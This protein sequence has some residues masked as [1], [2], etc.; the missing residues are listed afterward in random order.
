MIDANAWAG[1][2]MLAVALALLPIGFPVGFT[3]IGVSLLFAGAGILLGAFEPAFLSALP[4]RV[5]GLMDNDLLQA[6]PL[7]IYL[8]VILERTAIAP[9]M[10]QAL[11]ALFG[12]RAGGLGIAVVLVGAV[13]APTTGA[14]G[15]SVLTLGLLGLP[16]LLRGNYRKP[17][18]CGIVCSAGTLGTVL[19][20]SIILIV[21]ADLMRGANAQAQQLRGE[22]VSGA[23][24]ITDIYKGVLIP[25]A[26]VVL[27]YLLALMLIARR[28]PQWCP[29]MQAQR[30]PWRR[31]A[32]QLGIPLG[33]IVGL[34]IA[35]VT[36]V[37]YTVEAAAMGAVAA[38]L[39]AALRGRLDRQRLAETVRNVM[40][41][42]SMIFLLLIGASTFSL[43]FRG[44]GSDAGV[45]ALIVR[46]G[47]PVLAT[48]SV[49]AVM[50]TLGFFLD[51]LEIV[52]LV[53]PLAMP[54]LLALGADP[55]WLAVLAAL[56]VQTSFLMP[57]AGFALFF[58]RSVAPPDVAMTDIYRGVLPFLA[59]QLVVLALLWAWPPL[60]LWLPGALH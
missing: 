11:A 10:L 13:L 39:Y 56:T 18:A 24:V 49:F 50:F 55:I 58:M 1:F 16:I 23:I 3:L 54:S 21:L 35:I 29:P 30:P 40:R 12:R 26:L 25:V 33:F 42:T 6:I 45:H 47:S 59:I 19:P 53:V 4:L 32:L 48:A 46:L 31:L 17:L 38:T 15:A 44:F 37:L 7:F 51:A 57:P 27:L 20:P 52:S 34:L 60:A 28:H 43:I 22:T 2:A 41:L 9:E 14:V 5:I 8:G 36:G